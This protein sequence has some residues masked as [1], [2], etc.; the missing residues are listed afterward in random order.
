MRPE[1]DKEVSSNIMKQYPE[2]R[3]F[4]E[5]EPGTKVLVRL[6]LKFEVT[7]K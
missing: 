1:V 5:W 2:T 3:L 4:G 7:K 6:R